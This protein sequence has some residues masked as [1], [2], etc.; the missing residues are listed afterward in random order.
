MIRNPPWRK[1][2]TN[3]TARTA[4]LVLAIGSGF[5]ASTARAA[6]RPDRFLIG[7]WGIG[8]IGDP[9]RLVH[10]SDAGIDYV[11]NWDL[12]GPHGTRRMVAQIESLQVSH[13]GFRL[14]ALIHSRSLSTDPARIGEPSTEVADAAL[15]NKELEPATGLNGP[16]VLGWFVWDEPCDSAAIRRLGR[17]SRVL[18]SD[19]RSRDQIVFM[20]LLPLQEPGVSNCLDAYGPDR[21]GRYRAYVDAYLSQFDGLDTPAPVLSMDMYPFQAEG[22]E[23]RAY[24]ECLSIVRDKA[25]EYSRPGSRIPL[26][27][28]IQSSSY[29][30]ANE[31]EHRTPTIA[32]VR[33]Q[34]WCALAYGAKGIAYWTAVP[35]WNPK[36]REGWGDGLLDQDGRP[37]SKFAAIRSL[38]R[39]LQALGPTL[40]ELD[41]VS[42]L[43]VTP[44]NHVGLEN[45]VLGGSRAIYNIVA[46]VDAP[47]G[48]GD[49]LIGYLKHSRTGDDYLLVVNRS[50][51]RDRSFRITLA[52]P[53][54]SIERVSPATATLEPVAIDGRSFAVASLVP[55]AGAL[56][57]VHDAVEEYIPGVQTID[58]RGETVTFTTKE[59]RVTVDYRTG[60]RV[61][62]FG[63]GTAAPRAGAGPTD[64]NPRPRLR[65]T[66][67]GVEKIP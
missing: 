25:A 59:A 9:A 27:V 34:V 2:V 46:G 10:L 5:E 20:N 28:I 30:D 38:N 64:R 33:W 39:E 1:V 32:Q 14:Q 24:F 19:S 62:E 57:R 36:T 3:L 29:R 60:R 55:G 51:E 17:L 18:A 40:L 23:G 45:D 50:V 48:R 52:N 13:P 66:P 61:V 6:W 53:A 47:G 63:T 37:A 21:V 35:N 16:G 54:S 56:Y 65:A 49:C 22:R 11:Q 26:W 31:H 15:R 58:E 44:G 7:A 4:A 67:L 12:W 8:R 42:A 41:A 43:H